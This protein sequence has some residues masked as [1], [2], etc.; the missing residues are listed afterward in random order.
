MNILIL[1][2]V[3][4][5]E[6]IGKNT[7][8][9]VC[10]TEKIPCAPKP[11]LVRHRACAACGCGLCGRLVRQ[12]LRRA[13]SLCGLLVRHKPL[14]CGRPAC[15]A[16][17]AAQANCSTELPV[18]LGGFTARMACAGLRGNLFGENSFQCDTVYIYI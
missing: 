2:S 3:L 6:Y 10:C 14:A 13:I 5:W 16:Q 18:R 15:G 8:Y 17:A 1:Y 4:I 12:Q 9:I 7:I 11:G